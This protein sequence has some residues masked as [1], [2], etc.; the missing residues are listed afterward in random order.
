MTIK[1][2]NPASAKEEVALRLKTSEGE[3]RTPVAKPGETKSETFSATLGFTVDVTSDSDPQPPGAR[4]RTRSPTSSRR[5]APPKTA[6][7]PLVT[8]RRPAVLLP[9]ATTG[10]ACR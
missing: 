5:A 1:L 6:V 10:A 4:S 3:H 2:V 7:G 9:G 8:D